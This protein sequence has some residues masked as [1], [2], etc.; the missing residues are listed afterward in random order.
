[1]HYFDIYERHLARFRNQSPVMLEVGISGG[2]SLAMWKAYLGP[3]AKIIGVDINPECKAHEAEGIEV[4]IGSQ[5][6]P[7]LFEQIRAAYPTID[8][9]LD[10]GSHL[11][12]HMIRTFDIMYRC[13]S[14]RGVYM[15]EDTHA[16]Y[17][18][19]YEGGLKVSGSFMEFTK[20]R[21]DDINAAHSLGALPISEF[22]RSTDAICVYDSVVVFERRPQGRRQAPVTMAL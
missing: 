8:I 19:D 2:G 17:A 21:I 12:Q 14:D 4:F 7:A 9:F 16:C 20:D 5:D 1:M 6:D 13:L 15:V 18:P 3:G 10:D 22:T 11:Q